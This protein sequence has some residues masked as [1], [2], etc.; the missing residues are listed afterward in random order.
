[1]PGDD[2]G[3]VEQFNCAPMCPLHADGIVVLACQPQGMVWVEATRAV[4]SPIK[5][6]Q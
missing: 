3:G 6:L 2:Y 1:M 5:L 4:L